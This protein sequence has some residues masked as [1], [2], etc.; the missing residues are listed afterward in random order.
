MRPEDLDED[1]F[2]NL[3]SQ[4]EDHP[5]WEIDEGP[6][7]RQE[8]IDQAL[9]GGEGEVSYNHTET[10]GTLNVVI[11]DRGT[12]SG[13]M[14]A[15]LRQPLISELEQEE[16]EFAG[17]LRNAYQSIVEQNQTEYIE[18]SDD[19]SVI[20]GVN[21]PL[22]YSDTELRDTVEAV[23]QISTEVD[24]LHRELTSVTQQYQE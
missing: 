17:E 22:E 21:V 24:T 16:R 15:V 8:S 5:S 10:D 9:E 3:L 23:S 19:G 2:D 4:I 14:E 6:F 11:P 20:L 7:T 1:Y 18:P 13:A 12:P